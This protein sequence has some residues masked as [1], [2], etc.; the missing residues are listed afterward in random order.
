MGRMTGKWAMKKLDVSKSSPSC[1]LVA[2]DE[3]VHNLKPYLENLKFKVLSFE[4]GLDHDE[5]HQLLRKSKVHFFITIYGENYLDYYWSSIRNSPKYNM[6]WVKPDLLTD[7]NR[8][9]R[10][11]SEAI[12]Y[13]LRFR[14]PY[15]TY[16][17]INGQYITELP[18]IKKKYVRNKLK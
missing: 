4:S 16:V 12:L 1:F 18:K 7:L 15:P 3:N 5:I 14:H 17:K 6:L 10:A 2:V 13:D 11:I 9:S 8:T